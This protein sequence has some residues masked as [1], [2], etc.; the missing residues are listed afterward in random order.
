MVAALALALALVATVAVGPAAGDVRQ[1]SDPTLRLLERTPW[2]APEGE[3]VLTVALDDPPADGRVV[4]TVHDRL[5]GRFELDASIERDGLGAELARVVD[6]PVAEVAPEGVLRVV[7]PVTAGTADPDRLRLRDGGV[8]PVEVV[9]L[10]ADGEEVAALVTHLVRLPDEIEAT[11]AVAPTIDL[12]APPSLGPDGTVSVP[13][14]A[15]SRLTAVADVLTDHPDA[16]VTA[17][18]TPETL[19]ALGVGAALDRSLLDDLRALV[20]DGALVAGWSPWV[21]LDVAALDATG[22][23]AVV[24][25]QLAR[26]ASA[27]RTTL[28][29]DVDHAT[30]LLTDDPSPAELAALARHGAA[31]VV[32]P[33]SS[34]PPVDPNTFVVPLLRPFALV[35]GDALLTAVTP[36]PALQR[37]LDPAADDPVLAAHHALADLAAL[38]FDRPAYER[39]TPVVLPDPAVSP[40]LVD[41][42]LRGLT[43]SPLHRIGSVADVVDRTEL[44]A[45]GGTDAPLDDPADALLRAVLDQPPPAPLDDYA[46]QRALSRLAIDATA[47]VVTDTSVV[48]SLRDR[49]AVSASADL[50][51]TGRDLY[52]LGIADDIDAITRAVTVEGGRSVTLA[53]RD[54]TLPVTLRNDT[55]GP[56][57]V[58]LRFESD[59]LTFPDGERIDL[60]L[61]EAITPLEVPVRARAS[62]TFPLDLTLT[63]PDGVLELGSARYTVRSTAVSGLGL[64]L[65]GVA[66]AVIAAWWIRTARRV[67]RQRHAGTPLPESTAVG[68]D[69]HER[70]LGR[71]PVER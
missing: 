44:A 20:A 50:D 37:R 26:G 47:T 45:A 33:A 51:D 58:S 43:S 34:L 16:V 65:G 6:A 4:V 60:T 63:S 69:P 46:E 12:R 71:A 23:A 41:Q 29:A 19:E 57:R 1:R 11:L 18:F 68:S 5:R 61:T 24:D 31:R 36:D 21:D 59:K 15:R 39:S 42:L 52:V 40:I 22:L 9:A 48:R 54:G 25:E 8:H 3:L 10:D 7:V 38:W 13:A 49:L 27:L 2:V 67:R 14:V 32:L 62:G 55:G 30:V 17:T 28:G 53:A 66:V 56:V 64:V 70:E 35:A